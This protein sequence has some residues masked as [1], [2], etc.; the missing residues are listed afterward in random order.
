MLL[1]IGLPMFFLEMVLGQYAGLSATKVFAR[2]APGLRGLGYGMIC[3]PTLINFYYVVI[4]AYALHY[5]FAGFTSELPWGICGHKYNTPNCYSVLQAEDCGELEYFFDNACRNG[6]D[7]CPRIDGFY[8]DADYNETNCVREITVDNITEIEVLPFD[9]VTFKTS[10]SEDYWYRK[11]LNLA[12]EDGHLDTEINSWSKWGEVRWG[13]L[14]Y[15]A[16]SW[17]IICLALIGGIQSYGKLVYFTTLFPYVVLTILLGYVATLQGFSDGISYY[18]V[19]KDWSKMLDITVW[20]DAAGQIFY[21]LGVAVGSQLLLSSY[22]GFTANAHRDALLIGCCNSFT[23]FY[24]GFVVFGVIGY[25]ADV[26]DVDIDTVVTEGPGLAFIVYPEAVSI[27][28]ASPPFFSF[29]FFFMLN[30]L[31]I[32]SVC[33]SWEA[34]IGAIM[35]EFPVLRQK[36]VL[37]MTSTCFIAFLAGV[38]ICFDSGFLMFTLMD[39]RCG[40][41]ILL[42][43]LIEMIT[44]VWFYGG[45]KCMHH[46]KYEMMMPMPKFMEYFWLATWMVITPVIIFIV[47]VIAWAMFEGDSFEDYVFPAGVEVLGW[48]LEL[49][50]VMVLAFVTIYVIIKR[51]R[52]GKSVAFLEI[53][54]GPMMTPNYRWGPRPDRPMEKKEHIEEANE[55]IPEVN[56]A[57]EKV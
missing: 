49:T 22:N 52:A 21:S 44:I 53:K 46:V 5:L 48:M 31:A 30:L 10:A 29:L 55:K 23:S 14:G 4:M 24:A 40:N 8:F 12:F 37:V 16:L 39:T 38:S 18:I 13:L 34:M 33:A 43:A 51:L 17:L 25:I 36:R 42:M 54:V 50:G 6:S 1:L 57:F 56:D 28:P 35:D 26:K 9:N 41:A 7:F 27:M 47:T 45:T 20:N 11:V 3:I 15:L 32:S 19:P 2:M